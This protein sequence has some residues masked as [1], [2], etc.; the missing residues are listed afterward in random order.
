MGAREQYDELLRLADNFRKKGII[1]PKVRNTLIEVS[2]VTYARAVEGASNR[3]AKKSPRG[4][5][6]LK[7]SQGAA[8][9]L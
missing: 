2:T 8:F 4:E 3:I 6:G 7:G 1:D 9:T 5:R